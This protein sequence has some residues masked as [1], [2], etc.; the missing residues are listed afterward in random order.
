MSQ[1]NY[2]AIIPAEIRYDK[3]LSASEK[4]FYA[5]ITALTQMNGKCLASNS[6]FAEL[7]GVA[8]STISLWV[9]NLA[10]SGHVHIQYEYDGKQIVKRYISI[11]TPVGLRQIAQSEGSQK[12]EGV[13]RKSEGGSQK[14]RRGYSEN[15][16]EN[17]TLTESNTTPTE[18]NSNGRAKFSPPSVDDVLSL[19][20]DRRQSELFVS[21][22]ASV[23]WKVGKNPMKDW[24]SAVRGWMARN[25]IKPEEQLYGD[26]I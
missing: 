14:I 1:P 8:N 6:Y 3:N 21:Y 10:K 19:M 2:Y 9:S 18:S 15:Q 25:N 16:K 20:K 23:G 5:E 12:S 22:Y 26:V 4:L 11:E 7:Y 17:N 13:V 24:R